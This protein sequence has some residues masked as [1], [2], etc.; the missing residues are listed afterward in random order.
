CRI[1][2]EPI[3]GTFRLDEVKGEV[4][5]LL[6]NELRRRRLSRKTITNALSALAAML[7]AARDWNYMASELDW[8]KLRLPAEELQRTQRYF[9]PDES[10]RI[11]HA[12]PQQRH[13]CLN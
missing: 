4:P 5:Q 12:T 2:I 9:T 11:I 6:V 13:M 7:T 3:L 1:Y 10:Q 8:K